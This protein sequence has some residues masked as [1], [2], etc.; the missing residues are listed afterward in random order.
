MVQRYDDNPD[1][2]KIH[3]PAERE[4]TS[5][6]FEIAIAATGGTSTGAY[7]AGVLDFLWEALEEWTA[8]K[9]RGEA[10]K[11]AVRITTMVGTSAGGLSAAIAAMSGVKQFPHVYDERVWRQIHPDGRPQD[12]SK[13]PLYRAWVQEISL[14]RLLSKPED[15]E[16]GELALFYS[17]P[18]DV[19]D[20]IFKMIA[21]APVAQ[22][23][24]WLAHPLELRVPI[25]NLRG[26]PYALD[27]N[28]PSTELTRDEADA[29]KWSLDQRLSMHRDHVAFA[30]P[31]QAAGGK[32]TGK[33]DPPD[34]HHLD[35]GRL[36]TD[37]RWMPPNAPGPVSEDAGW[38]VFSRAIIATSAIPLVFRTVQ[39]LQDPYAYDWR[40]AWWEDGEPVRDMPVW[41]AEVPKE[42]V[43]TAT[44][45]GLYDDA[46][47]DM[48][49]RRLAGVRGR[50]PREGDKA[51]R[52]VILIDPIV[53]EAPEA[54]TDPSTDP[55][56]Q[57]DR[58]K[59]ENDKL[60]RVL[61]RLL[62]APIKQ[63][64]VSNFDL[65]LIKQ[66]SI[67]S[68]YMISPSRAHPSDD[69]VEWG[70]S[71]AMQTTPLSAFMG[72]TAEAYR[73]HDFLLGRRNAQQFLRK[74]FTLPK[75]NPLVGDGSKWKPTEKFVTHAG[76]EEYPIIPLRGT[77]EIEQ[78][79]PAWNCQALTDADIARLEAAAGK[80]ADALF[81]NLRERFGVG[82]LA[83]FGLKLLWFLLRKKIVAFFGAKLTEARDGL[84][85]L[86]RK[87]SVRAY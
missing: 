48:A 1:L 36:A 59:A 26:V 29:N 10:P 64:Q 4:G 16:T 17:A 28:N 38:T 80:R 33:G 35:A 85:P 11:Y 86:H 58:R 60:L 25:G 69:K 61:G 21:A 13:N 52:A 68:R 2:L 77:A 8:A 3:F 39:V 50:N 73:E 54:P 46:P 53:D 7:I 81:K 42:F 41:G 9:A 83:T 24:D 70:P 51:D 37:P 12:R 74:T 63:V 19:R 67:Y 87:R 32:P 65:A 40:T 20:T 76:V 71:L 31:T 75:G 15:A 57:P 44:D 78:P 45:G 30:L 47:F 56:G 55:T 43:Y 22:A 82:P 84:D 14:D 6:V 79:A 5:D 23:R 49:R 62:F 72:F 66:E 18:K 27:F 34:T